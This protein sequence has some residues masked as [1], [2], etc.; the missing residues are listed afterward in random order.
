[1]SLGDAMFNSGYWLHVKFETLCAHLKLLSPFKG[2]RLR[3]SGEKENMDS[4][5]ASF[6]V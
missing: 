2:D 6:L 4:K 5:N 1:M 3:E